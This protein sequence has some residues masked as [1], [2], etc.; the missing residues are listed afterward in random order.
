MK[1]QALKTY[2]ILL[3]LCV[4][5]LCIPAAAMG[6]EG[7]TFTITYK[8]NAGVEMGTVTY[9][10]GDSGN[11][12]PT[13]GFGTLFPDFMARAKQKGNVYLS[14]NLSDRWYSDPEFTVPAAFPN[15]QAGQ[16]Y[17]IY[18]KFTVGN[19]DAG[20]VGNNAGSV[21]YASIKTANA[22]LYLTGYSISGRNDV[23]EASKAV[24]EKLVDGQWAIVPDSYYIDDSGYTWPNIIWFRNVADSGAYRLKYY[25]Y[26]ATDENGAV[27][28]YVDA[29]SA[30]EHTVSILPASLTITGVQAQD[31]AYDGTTTVTL[32]GGALEGILYN[33]A[34]SFSLGKGTIADKEVG[35]GKSVT[36]NIQLTGEKAGN[37]TLTQPSDVTVNITAQADQQPS[38]PETGDDSLL[39]LWAAVLLTAG[40]GLAVMAAGGR[41]KKRGR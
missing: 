14:N 13:S 7:D 35:E 6:A 2:V 22:M 28:Y 18:C 3:M 36:T 40:T 15:G 37:Y 26:T 8:T 32:T 16:S 17:T 4:G 9:T 19:I 27:L 11:A 34:V 33:D 25:R 12:F 5:I 31:R 23:Y 1:K 38:I 30:G 24:F 41:K 20:T 21:P 10:V 39:A 29:A